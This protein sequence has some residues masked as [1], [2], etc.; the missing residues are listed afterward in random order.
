MEHFAFP[1]NTDSAADFH[2]FHV[3]F[4]KC[5]CV[6]SSSVKQCLQSVNHEQFP[7]QMT[8]KHSKWL[9]ILAQEDSPPKLLWSE[10]A[11]FKFSVNIEGEDVNKKLRRRENRLAQRRQLRQQETEKQRYRRL[12]YQRHYDRFTL[13]KTQIY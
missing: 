9:Q 10:N 3:L 7:M 12:E 8:H 6:Y 4:M 5:C 11:D 1:G 2:V 13:W